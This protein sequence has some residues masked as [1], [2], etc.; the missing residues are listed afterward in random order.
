MG[1]G[2][3][4]LSIGALLLGASRAVGVDIDAVAARTARENA[5]DNG[6]SEPVFTAVCADLINDPTISETIGT[7][8]DVI[9]ANIVA[10]VIIALSP[11]IR[12]YL[13]VG[14]ALVA[15]GVIEPRR[16]E[17]LVALQGVG[18]TIVHVEEKDGWCAIQCKG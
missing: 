15:S 4:I 8:Y 3:G 2:S 18:L 10:D 17:V 12:R 16:D 5:T 6:F 1:T 7:G 11:A 9:A 13:R 14:G